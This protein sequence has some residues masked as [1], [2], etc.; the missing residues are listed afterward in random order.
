MRVELPGGKIVQAR[1]LSGLI[2]TDDDEP[3]EWALY[4]DEQ[5][6][7]RTVDWPYRYVEWP[8]FDLPMDEADA[9]AAF[10]E[11]WQRAERGELIEIAC[12]GGTG[13]TGTALACIAHLAGVG[14]ADVVAWVRS[15][16][17]RWAVEVPEQEALIARF[18]RWAA[19]TGQSS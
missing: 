6:L 12:D 14:L 10:A 3:P 18:A 5:W 1:G 16:Y 7:E 8:D 11:A 4:L 9:F 17:H 2:S 15:H 19:A 13:R